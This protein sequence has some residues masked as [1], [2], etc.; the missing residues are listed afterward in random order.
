MEKN[1]LDFLLEE[2]Y[3]IDPGLREHGDNLRQL[4]LELLK[5]KPDTKFNQELAARLRQKILEKISTP[6]KAFNF[7]SFLV[8]RRWQVVFGIFVICIFSV[9]TVVTLHFSKNTPVKSDLYLAN[10]INDSQKVVRLEKGAFGSLGKLN[11]PDN[12]QEPELGRVAQIPLARSLTPVVSMAEDFS[13]NPVAGSELMPIYHGVQYVYGGEKFELSDQ[14]GLVF[15]RVKGDGFLAKSLAESLKNAN[16]EGVDLNTFQNLTITNLSFVENIDSGLMINF[17]F[18]NDNFYFS[19]NWEKWQVANRTSC[20]AGL[21]CVET[22]RLNLKEFPEDNFLIEKA[23]TFFSTHGISL[24]HYGQP[25]VDNSW[26]SSLTTSSNQDN[27]I[28]PEYSSLVFPLLIGDQKEVVYEQGGSYAGI[29]VLINLSKNIVSNVSGLS[30]YRYESSEYD[31]IN[32]S[33]RLISAAENSHRS[34]GYYRQEKVNQVIL[35]TP[36]K[37]YLQTWF[38]ENNKNEELLIPALLF[39]VKGEKSFYSSQQIIVPLV[40]EVF[41]NWNNNGQLRQVS[42]A[43]SGGVMET[44]P[45]YR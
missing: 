31:L 33:E 45:S 34:Q 22:A 42:P 8:S 6:E 39:P 28:F 41:E 21:D 3:E 14:T 32:D 27:F 16:F 38:Y 24:E 11:T 19:E 7:S 25:I 29:K 15:R 12:F 30:P 43:S 26:R 37:V 44:M 35:D 10:K 36:R 4:V 18:N 5:T 2:L 1:Q 20:S 13:G 23:N 9:T 17:D 40:R